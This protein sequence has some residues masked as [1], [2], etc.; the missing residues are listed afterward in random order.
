MPK[1]E[2]LDISNELH[3][4][5]L[6][7]RA[8]HHRRG[9]TAS[10]RRM[11]AS[12]V[13]R[14]VAV[15]PRGGGLATAARD[16]F[17]A[18]SRVHNAHCWAKPSSSSFAWNALSGTAFAGRNTA[19]F[20]SSPSFAASV[21]WGMAGASKGAS[22]VVRTARGAARVRGFATNRW[23]PR[24]DGTC[25]GKVGVGGGVIG[26]A[27]HHMKS[28]VKLPSGRVDVPAGAGP[29]AS[30]PHQPVRWYYNNAQ[31]GNNNQVRF[32]PP[33]TP[34]FD[35]E[36]MLTSLIGAN[37]FIFFLWQTVDPRFMRDN[38]TVS[39][40]SVYTGR[41]HTAVT[42][43][44]SH[45]D[46]YHYASN[47]LALYYFGRNI[48][49]VMGGTFLLNLYLAGGIVASVTHVVWCRWER[50]KRFGGGN[51]RKRNGVLQQA[52]RWMENNTGMGKQWRLS[53]PALGA[54]GAVNA[55][56]FLN[57]ALFP[58]QTIYLN[59]FIPMPNILFAGMFLARDVYGAQLGM[60]GSGTGHAAHLGGA[61]VGAAAWGLMRAGV[62]RKGG[63][64]WR[65]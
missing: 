54:S 44:F 6:S 2:R 22:E 62:F 57:A 36:Q 13:H 12:L 42:A 20:R 5:A 4:D 46:F 15:A 58:F 65:R 18:V 9:I 61:A 64:G 49:S 27:Q 24:T 47:M 51:N 8:S 52:G 53:P 59:F 38:F 32:P 19:T 60:G 28:M 33:A 3:P 34:R 50:E 26:T 31:G 56:V 7:A 10:S 29:F 17:G 39:E 35:G 40:A 1:K 14:A 48:G 23:N 30:K 25:T 21:A 55:V 45:Y 41:V 63:G 11:F 37:T 16:A 43:A